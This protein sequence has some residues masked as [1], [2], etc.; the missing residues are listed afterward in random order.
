MG[1]KAVTVEQLMGQDAGPRRGSMFWYGQE[2]VER[3]SAPKSNMKEIKD[4][5][6]SR[7]KRAVQ[8][9]FPQTETHDN[10]DQEVQFEL[11]ARPSQ[12]HLVLFEEEVGEEI[13]ERFVSAGKTLQLQDVAIQMYNSL[14]KL[15]LDAAQYILDAAKTKTLSLPKGSV[16]DELQQKGQD[17][18]VTVIDEFKEVQEEVKQGLSFGNEISEKDETGTVKNILDSSL[19]EIQEDIGR[20][21]DNDY[22][23][24]FPV[25]RVERSVSIFLAWDQ[26]AE[27]SYYGDGQGVKIG[28]ESPL[29][30]TL[31]DPFKLKKKYFGILPRWTV[32]SL[33]ARWS[34]GSF[35]YSS[36]HSA[37]ARSREIQ[38]LSGP[39]GSYLYHVALTGL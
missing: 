14:R 25:W 4:K 22:K 29:P 7:L 20:A 6:K 18:S 15:F 33:L 35:V 32:I 34:D 3:E 36:T 16:E 2:P 38:D 12:D 31:A 27:R 11:E 13:Q 8:K 37:S 24:E 5:I 28:L 9:A 21:V 39:C 17:F 30:P 23:E 10:P 26:A 1:Q 19:K